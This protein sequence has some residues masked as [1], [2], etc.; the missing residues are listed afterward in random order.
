MK[1]VFIIAEAGVN[2]NGKIDLAFK[3]I[4]EA[5]QAGANA[6]K[7]QTFKSENVV[8]K[9]ASRAQYQQRNMSE[10]EESQLEMIKRLE[11]QFDDFIKLKHYCDTVGIQFL[12]TPFDAES[13]DFVE[14]LVAIYKIPSG[15]ITNLPFLKQIAQKGKPIILSTGMSY[16]DEVDVAVRT[17]VQNQSEIQSAFPPLTLLH[18]TTNYPCPF[19]EVNLRA[20]QTLQ[21]AFQLPV[22]Y[23]DHTMGTEVPVAAVALGAV[24]IEKHFTLD[25]SMQGPD[26]KA[27][28]EPDELKQ[29]VKEIRNIET[30]LGDGIKRPNQSEMEIMQVVRKS[31]VASCALDAG[32][33]LS[34]EMIAIKRPAT[35]ISP[36]DLK[37]VLGLKINKCK[38]QDEVIEWQDLQ[39]TS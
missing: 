10:I 2:H 7:F 14:N 31:L 3:L 28:L 27:S 30:A 23:S 37:K 26:H 32:T 5:A 36:A 16:L 38:A 35:G 24:V 8:S 19:D 34:H 33:V 9:T 11:M 18:C 4:D 12:T 15:E 17:I 39:Q 1:K 22:G 21:Q 29:M 20:I 13:A 25:R 6:V